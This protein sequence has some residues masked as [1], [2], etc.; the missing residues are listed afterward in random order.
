M[1]NSETLNNS[2]TSSQRDQTVRRG[3]FAQLIELFSGSPEVIAM[4]E[5]IRRERDE[6][7][8]YHIIVK[9]V[10]LAF[11]VEFVIIGAS[12]FA[13]YH[14]AKIN[15]LTP[16]FYN[17]MKN[18]SGIEQVLRREKAD[19][20][21]ILGMLG[22]IGFA[23]V[24]LTRVPLALSVRF[25]RGFGI[26]VLAILGVIGASYLTAKSMASL[27]QQL[28]EPRRVLVVKAKAEF[29][30]AVEQKKLIYDQY[31]NLLDVAEEKNQRVIQIKE[32]QKQKTDT[33]QKNNCVAGRS[34]RIENGQVL[35]SQFCA[36]QALINTLRN[37]IADDEKSQA[38]A[39]KVYISAEQ[40]A[41]NFLETEVRKYETQ[42]ILTE[43][44]WTKAVTESQLYVLASVLLR[45]DIRQLQESDVAILLQYFIYIPAIMVA[46]AST[47]IAITA[48]YRVEKPKPLIIP[49]DSQSYLVGP[50][51]S[52]IT[53]RILE[54]L[55]K[56]EKKVNSD[57]EE[58]INREMKKGEAS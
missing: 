33:L 51:V 50:I 23:M 30:L 20:E 40:D 1:S 32:S 26:K 57:I 2:P 4:R 16:D 52:S 14:F 36:N 5:K 10:V 38:A 11:A 7:R 34:E 42:R 44:T 21:F 43:S 24:E 9:Q 54:E 15:I 25:Q 45:K 37:G 19:S 48:V 6:A 28:Y 18:L 41:K 13:A 47:L 8:G 39:Y 27:G 12:I 49:A 3:I 31:Q 35:T 17:E 56:T 53:Q 29:D 22:Q 58:N 55:R 46:L